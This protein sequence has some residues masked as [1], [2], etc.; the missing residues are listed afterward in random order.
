VVAVVCLMVYGGLRA[1]RDL[2]G[3]RADVHRVSVELGA[4]DSMDR[5]LGRLDTVITIL[6]RADSQ[7]VATN[8]KLD[9]ANAR[10]D[11]ADGA[12]GGM[13]LAVQQ[14][15]AQAKTLGPVRRDIAAM[16]HKIDGSFLFRGVK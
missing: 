2:E 4:V 15:D 11:H 7:L 16:A 13:T 14:M 12:I 3:M 10:L 6:R 8:A 5:K 9:H 1:I